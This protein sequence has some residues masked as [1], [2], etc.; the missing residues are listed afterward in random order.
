MATRLP[1]LLLYPVFVVLLILP[2]PS[3]F[4]LVLLI[5][6]S[7]ISFAVTSAPPSSSPQFFFHSHFYTSFCLPFHP[8]CFIMF[9]LLFS[10]LQPPS[11]VFPSCCHCC[12]FLFSASFH[13][14]P[15]LFFLFFSLSPIPLICLCSIIFS[16]PPLFPS[17][18]IKP[19]VSAVSCYKTDQAAPTYHISW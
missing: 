4:L 17:P 18:D 13:Y 6:H 1:L 3:S 11:L 7:P 10:L 5:S 2:S 15:C 16:L 8:L 9:L 14:S 12:L 19:S